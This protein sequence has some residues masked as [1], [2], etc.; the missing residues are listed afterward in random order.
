M[1]TTT[2]ASGAA[3]G[4]AKSAPA[5]RRIEEYL[6]R[7]RDALPAARADDVVREVSALIEDRLDVEGPER[8]TPEAVEHALG[9]LGPPDALA[10]AL[11]GDG[12]GVKPA[13]LRAFVRMLVVLFAAHVL[14]S[15]VLTVVSPGRSLV[16]GLAV[17]LEGDWFG[18]VGGVLSVFFADVGLLTVL[19]AVVGRDA[20]PR[21]CRG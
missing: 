1:S 16:P 13:V 14:L 8:G 9:A 4:P 5:A 2:P 17:P 7:L 10:A 18:I 12:S 11:V 15:I 21:S 6:E 3:P 19:F 20:G